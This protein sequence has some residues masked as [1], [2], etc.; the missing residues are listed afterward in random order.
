MVTGLIIAVVLVS[1]AAAAASRGSN[2]AAGSANRVAG[3][4]NVAVIHIDGE[5]LG[6]SSSGGLGSSGTASDDV[7]AM[8]Q[9]ARKAPNIK[10]VVL[11]INSPGG[12]AAGSAEIGEEIDRVRQ[13]GKK[14]VTSMGD[15]A[16]SGAYWISAKTDKIVANQATLT[17]S[18]GV[19]MQTMDLQ[20][21]YNK[22]G[23]APET[24][25]SGPYK[26]MGGSNRAVTPEEQQ[27]FQGMIDDIYQQFV[28]VVAQG[29]HMSVDDVRKLADGRVYT[30]R[31]AQ[32]LG[33]VDQ[34]GDLSDAVHLAGRLAGIKG[35]PVVTEL[36]S[37]NVWRGLLGL[38]GQKANS[39]S[40][41]LM[42]LNGQLNPNLLE[43]PIQAR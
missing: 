30:G 17:G 15:E 32:K 20:G 34:F 40:S 6:G 22:L 19:I 12:S 11:R 36:G 33:L 25:K 14:V 28:D 38:G 10:A 23:V 43:E 29:R 21:L 4:A 18:I 7:V 1:L 37:S 16:A 5:I 8:L 24:F 26:D 2:R 41:Y 42:L 3:N 39:L 35:E 9:Q 31:Q 13:A 27:I